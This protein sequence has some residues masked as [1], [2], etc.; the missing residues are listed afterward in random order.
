[1]ASV[2][3][4]A[5]FAAIVRV[6]IVALP[7]YREDWRPAIWALAVL[8]LVVGS[9]LAVVQTNVKRMLAYSSISHAG[10]LLV[11]IEAAGHRAGES[12]PGTGVVALV[13]YL[14]AYSVLVIGT[15]GVV[16]VVGRNTSGDVT[17]DAFK[18]LS[19]RR[20]AL[21]L[22]LT[23]FLFAQ[24]GVPFT[25][26]FVAKFGV[27]QAAVEERSY[28]IAIIAMV[29]AVIAAFLYLRIMVSVW[30]SGSTETSSDNSAEATDG[31]PDRTLQIPVAAGLAI[32]AAAI[33]TVAVGILPGWLIS[34]AEAVT[35]FAR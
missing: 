9:A 8:S 35:T 12:D 34:T 27:I 10:F 33:F 20:P 7:F 4:A 14:L 29:A 15:F 16:T 23:V 19:T 5:A 1:M 13:I 18:G 28:A 26:G 11:A 32:G 6:L 25:S 17:L 2:G 24:A 30:L 21:A 3:K 31:S 22:A